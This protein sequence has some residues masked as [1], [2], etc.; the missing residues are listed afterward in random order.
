MINAYVVSYP[1]KETK[2]I[3]SHLKKKIKFTSLKRS[4]IIIVVGGDGF[5]LQ[6]L[7]KY[8]RFKKSFYGF[9]NFLDGSDDFF[10]G[11]KVEQIDGKVFKNI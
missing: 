7:K 3:I 6:T 8:Y 5:M 10:D 11:K 1:H 2:K 9:V 4:K